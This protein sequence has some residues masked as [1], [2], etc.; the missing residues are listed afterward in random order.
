MSK[1]LRG[2]L[3][4]NHAAAQEMHRWAVR[5][6]RAGET[7]WR[8]LEVDIFSGLRTSVGGLWILQ[9][10][11]SCRRNFGGV[12]FCI[13]A[14]R[15]LLWLRKRMGRLGKIWLKIAHMRDL[16]QSVPQLDVWSFMM[17][18]CCLD[19]K[20]HLPRAQSASY[21]PSAREKIS[22]RASGREAGDT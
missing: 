9:Q 19:E 5:R 12:F 15:A 6:H 4:S 14:G 16:L 17:Q 1:T 13:Y 10:P 18:A 11:R 8:R 22:S 3:I 20:L 2:G 21:H 7:C